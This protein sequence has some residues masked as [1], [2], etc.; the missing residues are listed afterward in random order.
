M[1]DLPYCDI[2]MKGGITSGVVYPPAIHGLSQKFR[3]KNVGGASAGAIAAALTAAAEY[4][5]GKPGAG[6]DELARLPAWLG[7]KAPGGRMSNLNALFQPQ[8]QTRPLFRIL[9]TVRGR[10]RWKI[11]CTLLTLLRSYPISSLLGAVPGAVALG[12]LSRGGRGVWHLLAILCALVFVAVGA[13][14]GAAIRA[15]F[16]ARSA[17][18]R[19]GY[20]MCLGW[21]RREDGKPVQLAEWLSGLINQ[22]AGR[23]PEDPPLTFGDLWGSKDPSAPRNLNLAMMTSDLT[24]GRPFRLPFEEDI[25]YFH[26]LEFRKLF[27]PHVVQWMVDHPRETDDADKHAPL[28]PMPAASDLP[29]IVAAR[30]SLSFPLLISAVPVYA[31]DYSRPEDKGHKPERCWF[32]DGGITSNFPVHFFDSVLPRWPTFAINLRTFHPD[33]PNEDVWMPKNNAGGTSESWNRF[34]QRDEGKRLTG[35]LAAILD[36]MQNWMD[37]SQLRMPGYRDRVAHVCLRATEG[38]MNL[39]MP[40]E[41]VAALGDR[42]RRA[43]A[44]LA[45]RFTTPDHPM[46]WDNH[47]WIRFRSAL[48]LIEQT[49]ERTAAAYDHAP[50]GA[51]TYEALITRGPDSP[52]KSYPWTSQAQRDGALTALRQLVALGKEWEKT[53]ETF[54]ANAPNPRPTLRIMPRI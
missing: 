15:L 12:A 1:T 23:K 27:P 47:R 32:S 49:L 28:R 54:T 9:S 33:Y 18:P 44:M 34:D 51:I 17:L 3:F 40:R 50:Q 45:D 31:V 53:K 4:G 2:V 26:P 25:F 10:G 24:H 48:A 39:D 6:F 19:N 7:G 22:L 35:F 5:R 29:V 14:L 38:G 13:L 16:D 36:T 43:A 52:P 42:G 20:G 37:N 46:G 11:P 8:A 41:V 30:M 21:A